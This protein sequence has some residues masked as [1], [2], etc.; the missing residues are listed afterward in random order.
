MVNWILL[1]QVDSTY[2]PAVHGTEPISTQLR[3]S[4]RENQCNDWSNGT[5]E[6]NNLTYKGG[7]SQ[8]PFSESK[9]P[10]PSSPVSTT[11]GETYQ[12]YVATA[13]TAD[14]VERRAVPYWSWVQ[15]LVCQKPRPPRC[16]HC[17]LC[18]RCVLK[19][20]HHCFFGRNCVGFS[21]QRFFIFFLAWS[22]VLTG[23]GTY[24]LP[25]YVFRHILT[26]YSY[27]DFVWPV[28]VVRTI[29]GYFPPLYLHLAGVS[30]G[31]MILL[32]FSTFMLFAHLNLVLRGVTSFEFDAKVK[33]AD[34]RPWAGRLRAVLGANWGFSLL[35]PGYTWSAPLEDPVYWPYLKVS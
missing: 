34:T 17:A 7:T 19:R 22:A 11:D 30:L 1:W 13:I 15:C 3:A 21:N 6:T 27:W 25:P 31:T 35:L 28:N 33:V 9:D 8:P 4:L 10:A 24:L 23:W 29:L 5:T 32:V 2:D 20:D 14:G 18:K 26:Q 12:V 16:H